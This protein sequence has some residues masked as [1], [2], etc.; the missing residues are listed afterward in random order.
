MTAASKRLEQEP[1]AESDEELI[2]RQDFLFIDL[3]PMSAQ[4][5]PAPS[6]IVSGPITSQSWDSSWRDGSH[7]NAVVECGRMQVRIPTPI[8]RSS[9]SVVYIFFP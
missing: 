8:R 9:C 1:V 5:S 3:N 7:S 2:I 4:C 6:E